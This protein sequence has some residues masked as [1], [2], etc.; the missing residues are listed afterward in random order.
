MLES[1]NFKNYKPI[2]AESK[3]ARYKNSKTKFKDLEGVGTEKIII[4]SNI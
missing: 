2:R 3:S 4:P 1:L